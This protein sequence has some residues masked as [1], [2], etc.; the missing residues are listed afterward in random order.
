MCFLV[1]VT[2]MTYC[3]R[4]ATTGS[5]MMEMCILTFLI[6]LPLV[7][8]I[9][10]LYFTVPYFIE[11][12]DAEDAQKTPVS[13]C[14]PTRVLGLIERV[15]PDSDQFKLKCNGLN[16]GENLGVLLTECFDTS[17][18]VP[19]KHYITSKSNFWCENS[20]IHNIV[21][22]KTIVEK[23]ESIV[24]FEADPPLPEPCTIDGDDQTAND[25]N[26]FYVEE[27]FQSDVEHILV[28]WRVRERNSVVPIQE[29]PIL[30][31][32]IPGFPSAIIFSRP[33]MYFTGFQKECRPG[34]P[35]DEVLVPYSI[36]L[37]KIHKNYPNVEYRNKPGSSKYDSDE[38]SD[39]IDDERNGAEVGADD[40]FIKETPKDITVSPEPVK[41]T[42]RETKKPATRRTPRP[43]TPDKLSMLDKEVFAKVDSNILS[44]EMGESAIKRSKLPEVEPTNSRVAVYWS[45]S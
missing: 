42:V 10:A 25:E 39:Y 6:T 43:V 33:G 1:T 21:A 40:E 26:Y 45:C 20:I 8:I 27:R 19:D 23:R 18:P 2:L 32:C 7:V 37:S 13:P 35:F 11:D 14:D 12:E 30:S 5:C 17:E 22:F 9:T 38:S 16:F 41:K 15:Y 31:Y 34:E 44:D 28:G 4:K 29:I 3:I 24:I 36:F